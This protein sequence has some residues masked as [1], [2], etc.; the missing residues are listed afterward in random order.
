MNITYSGKHIPRSPFKVKVSPSSDAS[1]VKVTGPGIK[2]EGVKSLEPTYFEVDA[3]E[4]GEGN[5]DINIDPTGNFPLSLSLVVGI[6]TNFYLKFKRMIS[7]LSL[8]RK[9]GKKVT[10]LLKFTY[11]LA[12]CG[13]NTFLEILMLINPLFKILLNKDGVICFC[14]EY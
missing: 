6:F 8:P 13:D 12:K 7:F 3:S 11:F 14:S 10:N 5:V 4:A 9:T 2:A 1:K